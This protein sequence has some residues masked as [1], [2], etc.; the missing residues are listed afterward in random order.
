MQVEIAKPLKKVKKGNAAGITGVIAEMLTTSGEWLTLSPPCPGKKISQKIKNK[1]N[2]KNLLIDIHHANV[3]ID[4][5][6]LRRI[7]T[8]CSDGIFCWMPNI[9]G[10]EAVKRLTDICNSIVNEE[11]IPSDWKGST[12]VPVYKGKGDPM[13]CGSYH[14]YKLLQHAM[15]VV[16]SVGE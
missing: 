1:I 12:L 15:K 16:E 8:A 11:R 6:G 3:A 14:A 2:T 10:C 9:S 7:K 4:Q 5:V 13:Q